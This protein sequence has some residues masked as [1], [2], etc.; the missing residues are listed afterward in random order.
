M[1]S[2]RYDGMYDEFS[3]LVSKAEKEVKERVEEALEISKTFVSSGRAGR[4]DL[5]IDRY[6]DIKLLVEVRE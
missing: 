1:N 3:A 4:L 5:H 6:G 2:F